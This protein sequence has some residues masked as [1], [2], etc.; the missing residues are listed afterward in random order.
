[1]AQEC[2]SR[3][4]APEVIRTRTTIEVYLFLAILFSEYRG[5]LAQNR[6]KR[7]RHFFGVILVVYLGPYY[8][9]FIR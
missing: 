5:S 6:R 7:I 1:M 9:V 8:G 4:E 2:T 3:S